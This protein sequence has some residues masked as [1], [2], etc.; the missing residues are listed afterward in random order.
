MRLSDPSTSVEHPI[1][2]D[3][4]NRGR[5]RPKVCRNFDVS[6]RELEGRSP[7]VGKR[8]RRA[9]ARMA[10][11]SPGS[12]GQL[13]AL[14]SITCTGIAVPRRFAL[15]RPHGRSRSVSGRRM[16]ADN[17]CAVASAN[18]SAPVGAPYWS[19]ITAEFVAF[20]RETQHRAG[21][22]VATC[23]VNPTRAQDQVRAAAGTDQLFALQL[24]SG[25]RRS[26]DRSDRLPPRVQMPDPSNT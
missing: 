3:S 18:S 26:R 21:E 16:L 13:P 12:V 5:S 4:A 25:R 19:S 23:R 7:A 14:D 1:D 2:A 22:I 15:A 20:R 10:P 11:A 24:G 17:T 8:R 6:S 9:P